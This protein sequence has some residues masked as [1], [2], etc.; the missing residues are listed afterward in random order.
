MEIN[1]LMDMNVPYMDFTNFTNGEY[2]LFNNSYNLSITPKI[3]DLKE[4]RLQIQNFTHRDNN[5]KYKVHK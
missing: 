1:Q 4:L 2:E 3:K 5:S